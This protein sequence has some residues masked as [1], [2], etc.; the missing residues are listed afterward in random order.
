MKYLHDPVL[1]KPLY[2]QLLVRVV[3][4]QRLV[5]GIL[6]PIISPAFSLL[7][8]L[9]WGKQM[10]ADIVAWHTFVFS[11]NM[12]CQTLTCS[13]HQH[14]LFFTPTLTRVKSLQ[15]TVVI[16][17]HLCCDPLMLLHF[18]HFPTKWVATVKYFLSLCS[19]YWTGFKVVFWLPLLPS[20][21]W[22]QFSLCW[23]HH[24]V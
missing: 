22:P 16:A 21:L 6:E 11:F 17:T 5:K 3:H 9:P 1:D 7:P 14:T 20:L 18:S 24:S 19:V 2:Q 13:L 15:S 12:I 23:C 8:F 10:N 4:L